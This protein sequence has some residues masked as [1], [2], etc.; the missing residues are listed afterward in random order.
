[1]IITTVDLTV[2]DVSQDINLNYVL[3]FKVSKGNTPYFTLRI[4]VNK[5]PIVVFL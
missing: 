1:M 3:Y 5:G 4:S 2:T